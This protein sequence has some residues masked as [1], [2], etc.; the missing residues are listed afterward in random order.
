MN[1]KNFD[2]TLSEEDYLKKHL[3]EIESKSSFRLKDSNNIKSEVTTISNL[4]YFSFDVKEFPCGLYYPVGTT[5]QIRAAEVAEIQ[6]YSMV[7]DRNYPDVVSKMTDMLSTCVRVKYP[8]G[9]IG[10]YL[11]IKDADRIYLIFCIRELTF[12]QGNYLISKTT[13]SCGQEVNIELRR[14]NFVFNRMEKLS[15]YFNPSMRCYTFV[16][17]N[18]N[19]FNLGAPTIGVQ[20]AF[21]DFISKNVAEGKK[22]DMSFIKIIPFTLFDRNNISQEGI[23]SKLEEFKKMD[24]DSFQFINSAVDRLSFGIK[25]VVKYCSCGLEVRSTEVFPDGASSIFVIHDA[26]EKYIKE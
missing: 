5:I 14:E 19:T 16:T 25:E 13:C 3:E 22:L 7:D 15:K 24:M 11:D 26:F 1:E 23:K 4:K 6:A 21:V 20:K 9:N 12:Q 10:S 8:D 17:N 2:K 18:S